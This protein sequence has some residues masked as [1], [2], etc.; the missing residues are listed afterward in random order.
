[1]VDRRELLDD[2]RF[3]TGAARLAHAAECVEVIDGIFASRTLAEWQDQLSALTTPWMV[4][5]TAAEASRDRQV[6]ANGM[7][8]DVDAPW[9]SFPLVASPAQFDGVR[10]TLTRAP[11]HGEHT[12]EVLLELGR[13]WEEITELKGLG[14]AL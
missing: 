10:L 3:A 13:S 2:P 6:V 5:Q 8:V 1:M 4:V 12:E 7:V 11:D 9:G 14:A